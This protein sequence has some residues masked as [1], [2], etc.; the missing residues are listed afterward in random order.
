[1]RGRLA[2]V[3]LVLALPAALFALWWIASAGSTSFYAP[4]LSKIIASFV[5]TWS[6]RLRADVL[7]SIARL[8]IGY[9]GAVIAGVGLGVGLGERP[10]LRAVVEPVLE[11]VRAI[12]PPALVPVFMLLFGIGAPMKVLVI[13]SGAIWPVLLNTIEGVRA[14]DDVLAD[15]CRSYGITGATRLRVLVLRAASPQIVTGMRQ[16]LSIAIILMVISEMFASSSGLGFA[17][18]DF[19]RGFSIPEMWSGIL[20]LGLLGF[21]LSLGFRVFEARVLRWYHEPR[22]PQPGGA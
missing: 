21:V 10:R 1:V 7:P 6:P 13:A 5:P 16:A 18:V 11:L 17:I 2:P 8:L 4:P 14:I 15:T 20:V 22:R 3:A 19:Q 12:P 9:A